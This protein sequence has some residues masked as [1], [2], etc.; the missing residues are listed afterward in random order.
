MHI[1]QGQRTEFE[2]G[3]ESSATLLLNAACKLANDLDVDTA[4]TLIDKSFEY[5]AN[6]LTYQVEDLLLFA[7]KINEAI[8]LMP[9]KIDLRCMKFAIDLCFAS[10]SLD[11]QFSC[12]R[13]IIHREDICKKI[14][15]KT[16]ELYFQQF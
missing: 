16:L 10:A 13:S 6:Q 8:S 9:D 12:R 14:H 11:A 4:V 2:Q 3:I 1:E 5:A 15:R 7:R